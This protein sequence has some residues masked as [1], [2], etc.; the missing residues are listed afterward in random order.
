[1]NKYD[2]CWAVWDLVD[3]LI[4]K[5]IEEKKFDLD[6]LLEIQDQ[7]RVNSRKYKQ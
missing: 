6:V 4:K 2:T 7:I 3:K 5:N 1:M